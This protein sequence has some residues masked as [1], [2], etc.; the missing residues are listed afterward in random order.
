VSAQPQP[1]QCKLKEGEVVVCRKPVITGNDSPT[2][3]DL[4]EEPLS[5]DILIV[6]TLCHFLAHLISLCSVARPGMLLYLASG[7]F[8]TCSNRN[9]DITTRLAPT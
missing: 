5:V 2:T 3:F 4:V 7:I 1:D 9:S 8:V 6:P